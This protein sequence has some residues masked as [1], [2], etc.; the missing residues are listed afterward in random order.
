MLLKLAH[1]RLDHLTYLI[2]L[3]IGE[4]SALSGCVHVVLIS[5]L[6]VGPIHIGSL[7]LLLLLMRCK[8]LHLLLVLRLRVHSNPVRG[9]RRRSHW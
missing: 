6:I 7:R 9:A 8:L 2:Y 5:L 4:Q 1:S 3:V